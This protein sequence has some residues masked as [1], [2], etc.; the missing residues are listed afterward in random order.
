MCSVHFQDVFLNVFIEILML[1]QCSCILYHRICGVQAV[2]F[3]GGR[4]LYK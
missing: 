3:L 2:E 1:V 4:T